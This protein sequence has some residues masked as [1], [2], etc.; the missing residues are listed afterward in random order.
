M[1][2]AVDVVLFTGCGT[3]YYLAIAAARYYQAVTG[4]FAIAVPASELFF[5]HRHFYIKE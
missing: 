4:E 1:K 3:S 5:T 2:K